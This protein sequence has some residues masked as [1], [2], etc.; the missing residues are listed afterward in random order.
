MEYLS[1][2]EQFKEVLNQEE[3]ERIEDYELREIRRK[4]WQKQHQAFL[5]EKDI[6]DAMLETVS[7]R[8]QE[9]ERA[10]LEK[11]KEKHGI[12]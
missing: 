8:I 2:E 4:Y 11:Y 12:K 5:N 6:P 9:E 7:K 10:E 3:I 1:L